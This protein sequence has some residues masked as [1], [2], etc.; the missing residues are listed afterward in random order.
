MGS[1]CRDQSTRW[2][3]NAPEP[4]AGSP[5]QCRWPPIM[6]ANFYQSA[7]N[8]LNAFARLSAHRQPV[9]NE[10][11]SPVYKPRAPRSLPAQMRKSGFSKAGI[12][13]PVRRGG[14]SR[15]HRHCMNA[16]RHGRQGVSR[17]CRTGLGKGGRVFPR[18]RSP[19]GTHRA[20]PPTTS[21]PAAASALDPYQEVSGARSRMALAAMG[22]RSSRRWPMLLCGAEKRPI[23][24]I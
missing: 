12:A 24:L 5:E 14:L 13:D 22:G 8:D 20:P 2:S 7:P 17:I 19:G 1:R 21:D 15:H 11:R 3:R 9:R 6:P 10:V 4:M 16:I 18:A 23:W